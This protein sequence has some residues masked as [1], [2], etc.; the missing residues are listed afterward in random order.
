VRLVSNL[1]KTNGNLKAT[2]EVRTCPLF[3][4]CYVQYWASDVFSEVF[5]RLALRTVRDET[6]F[7]LIFICFRV[8]VEM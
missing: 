2:A 5:G 1:V 4:A 3:S 8:R 6:I 7:G